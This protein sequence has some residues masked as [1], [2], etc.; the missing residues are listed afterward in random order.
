MK[1]AR[2]DHALLSAA[3][4]RAEEKTSAEIVVAVQPRSSQVTDIAAAIG[5]LAAFAGLL[6]VLFVDVEFDPLHVAPVVFGTGWV[7]FALVYGAVPPALLAP[8]RTRRNVDDAAHAA[9]SRNGVYRTRDRTGVLVFYSLHERTGRILV[10]TG[11]AHAVAA[12]VRDEWRARLV[13]C[14]D[15]AELIA[16]IEDIGLRTGQVLP[17]GADDVDELA[18]TAE[19]AS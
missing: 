11:V 18:N 14:R 7:A 19:V 15:A 16:L 2:D 17:R 12:D 10:D 1:F 3:V 13:A 6:A 4:G 8:G 5:A 9:F